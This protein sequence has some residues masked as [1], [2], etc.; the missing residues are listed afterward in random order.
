MSSF[1][2]IFFLSSFVRGCEDKSHSS[3]KFAHMLERKNILNRKCRKNCGCRPVSLFIVRSLWLS[4][5]EVLKTE[6]GS[7]NDCF[8]TAFVFVFL[9]NLSLHI[10]PCLIAELLQRT[11]DEARFD[12]PNLAKH[13]WASSPLCCIAK[14]PKHGHFTQ[15]RRWFDAVGVKKQQGC[16][17]SLLVAEIEKITSV[18]QI[19]TTV[20]W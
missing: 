3:L 12:F 6:G 5:F 7:R 9:E 10:W 11:S 17:A 16:C 13:C 20:V 8:F 1:R 15:N 2:L 4:C 19:E 18:E 14:C